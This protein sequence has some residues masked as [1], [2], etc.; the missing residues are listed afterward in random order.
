MKKNILD[1]N[2]DGKAAR[3]IWFKLMEGINM[4]FNETDFYVWTAC[5]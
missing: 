2:S 3:K 5:N 4:G 1:S